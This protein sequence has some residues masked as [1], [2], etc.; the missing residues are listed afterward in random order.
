MVTQRN[1]NI[2][3]QVGAWAFLRNGSIVYRGKKI[4]YTISLVTK[5]NQECYVTDICRN[6][7]NKQAEARTSR[8]NSFANNVI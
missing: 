2:K 5:T 3:S 7:P 1:A 4:Q 8:S 6:L